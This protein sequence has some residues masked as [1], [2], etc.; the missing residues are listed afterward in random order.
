MNSLQSVA[1]LTSTVYFIDNY[2]KQVL[3]QSTEHDQI[4]VLLGDNMMFLSEMIE[5]VHNMMSTYGDDLKKYNSLGLVYMDSTDDISAYME[6]TP[7]FEEMLTRKSRLIT[8]Y[9]RNNKTTDWYPDLFQRTKSKMQDITEQVLGQSFT[10][11]LMF[12][13]DRF[14]K[15]SGG[16]PASGI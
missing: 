13:F 11:R 16:K 1:L 2:I 3:S 15:R 9:N 10:V 14:K 7:K 8:T 6:K 4:I 12:T 5:G